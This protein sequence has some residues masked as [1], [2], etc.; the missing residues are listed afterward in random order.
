[1]AGERVLREVRLTERHRPIGATRH[2]ARGSLL[3]AP[4][5]LRISQYGAAP[6]FYL[7]T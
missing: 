5:M 6:G 4:V 2:F 1:M 7:S 3:P